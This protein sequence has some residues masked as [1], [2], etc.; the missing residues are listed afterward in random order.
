MNNIYNFKSI[1]EKIRKERKELGMNQEQL[2][3]ALNISSRQT[4]AKW[5]K[6]ST[7]PQLEDMLN[8]CNLFGCELGYLLGEYE[9]KTRA[10]TD[11]QEQTGLSPKSIEY[12]KY[13]HSEAR[14]IPEDN[15]DTNPANFDIILRTINFLLESDKYTHDSPKYNGL[16]GA[17]TDYLYGNFLYYYDDD[18][19]SY[20]DLYMHVEM[21][22][23]WDKELGTGIS[24]ENETLI[25]NSL[26]TSIQEKLLYAREHLQ[27][28][29]PKRITPPGDPFDKE[30][31]YEYY[32][33]IGD[34]IKDE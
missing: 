12:L 14:R 19:V 18:T 30:A 13:A 16:L 20:E 23:L 34:L 11:I 17:I 24:L 21:L 31:D 1:G 8:M 9:L 25:T 26:M 22:G 7:I 4:I 10:A 33:N 27:R 15:F 3:S 28:N 5:E 32:E 6:G 2:A 29:L